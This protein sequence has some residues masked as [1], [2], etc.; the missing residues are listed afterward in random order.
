MTTY[1]KTN[2]K[3]NERLVLEA[4][5][6]N[7]GTGPGMA[8]QTVK[9]KTGL[10]FRQLITAT[11]HLVEDGR[12]E[13]I[14]TGGEVWYYIANPEDREAP[15]PATPSHTFTPSPFE[16]PTAPA[17]DFGTSR[18]TPDDPTD[19]EDEDEY[20]SVGF[21]EAIEVGKQTGDWSGLVRAI[22]TP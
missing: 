1:K 13:K 11:K 17:N 20:E 7:G 8:R 22:A 15:Q 5:R 6:N 19:D 9:L 21:A 10:S 4:I 2:T 16:S 18:A 12:L 3:L 14:K